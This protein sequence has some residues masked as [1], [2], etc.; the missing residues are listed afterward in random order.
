MRHFLTRL[1]C[2]PSIPPV[3]TSVIS[4]PKI[5]QVKGFRSRRQRK[6][7]FSRIFSLNMLEDDISFC[8]IFS[9][10]NPM[11]KWWLTIR[12]LGSRPHCSSLGQNLRLCRQRETLP[13]SLG[14]RLKAGARPCYS[15]SMLSSLVFPLRRV[16][17]VLLLLGRGEERLSKSAFLEEPR[18]Q[19][20]PAAWRRTAAPF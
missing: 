20:S 14:L 2:H 3:L 17:L 18:E 13:L 9:P 5:K 15:S 10:I 6:T 12:G 8:S 7:I 19:R 4:Q 11:L 1:N 16:A